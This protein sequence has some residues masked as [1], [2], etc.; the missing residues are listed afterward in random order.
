MSA[1]ILPPRDPH[2]PRDLYPPEGFPLK[3]LENVK[4]AFTAIQASTCDPRAEMLKECCSGIRAMCQ[5]A[6]RLDAEWERIER[7]GYALKRSIL[8]LLHY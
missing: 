4:D 8:S 6:I 7:R 1:S 3:S 5:E 2:P